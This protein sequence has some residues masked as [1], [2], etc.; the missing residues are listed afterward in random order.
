MSQK[1][2]LFNWFISL[3]NNPMNEQQLID[4]QTKEGFS[5][6]NLRVPENFVGFLTYG[7]IVDDWKYKDLRLNK[8][9]DTLLKEWESRDIFEILGIQCRNEFLTLKNGL[10]IVSK[11]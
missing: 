11:K 2:Q 10:L 3:V 1:I 8:T 5:E 4:L 7:T 6:L 9:L